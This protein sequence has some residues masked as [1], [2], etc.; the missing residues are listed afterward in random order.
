M[1]DWNFVKEEILEVLDNNGVHDGTLA[2]LEN[3][4]QVFIN[5]LER[6]FRPEAGEPDDD[7]DS[8]W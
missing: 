5:K 4:V 1:I 8:D 2:G 6:T 3:K 7:T